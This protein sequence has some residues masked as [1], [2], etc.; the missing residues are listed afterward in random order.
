MT[1]ASNIETSVRAA[2][3]LRVPHEEA[4]H[5]ILRLVDGTN[6]FDERRGT[7]TPQTSRGEHTV[8]DI[9]IDTG[10]QKCA[11]RTEMLALLLYGRAIG[12]AFEEFLR[13]VRA[14]K[15]DLNDTDVLAFV[16]DLMIDVG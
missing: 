3:P 1:L 9:R 12:I 14:R 15:A 7:T 6:S 2:S 5:L 8:A 4:C 16:A 11:D 13:S 10:D